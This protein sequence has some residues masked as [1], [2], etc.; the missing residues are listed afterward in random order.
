MAIDKTP[1]QSSAIQS[2]GYDPSTRIIHVEFRSGG[3]HRF[4]PFEKEE[5]DR[6]RNA[7]SIGKHF[8]SHIRVKAIK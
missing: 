1:V 2:V 7:G 5:F 3:T 6:F 4:G 8:H